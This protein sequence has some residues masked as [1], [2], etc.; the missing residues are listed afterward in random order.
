MTWQLQRQLPLE[1]SHKY[2]VQ[3]EVL[4]TDRIGL[5]EY[6]LEVLFVE[7]RDQFQT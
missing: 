1:A 7:E 5:A 4:A 2:F 3:R 6:I